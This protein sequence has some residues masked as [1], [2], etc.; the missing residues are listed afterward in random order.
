MNRT[1]SSRGISASDRPII[2]RRLNCNE[3]V[4]VLATEY[5]VPVKTI[6]RIKLEKDETDSD[7]VQNRNPKQRKRKIQTNL[8]LHD[9]GEILKRLEAGQTVKFLMEKYNV[10]RK[11]IQRIIKRKDILLE[12]VKSFKT[13]N[14]S[15]TV[16][17]ISNPQDSTLDKALFTWFLQRRST[18]EPVSGTMLQEQSL[19]F[20]EK[21]ERSS[22]NFK[23][24]NGWLDKFKKRHGIQQLSTQGDTLSADN[25][26]IEEFAKSLAYFIQQNGYEF[27][28]IYNADESGLYWKSFPNKNPRFLEERNTAR[29]TNSNNRITAMFCANASGTHKIPLLIIGESGQPESLK[30]VRNLPVKY[31]GQ[32]N[33][34]MDTSVFMEWYLELFIPEV[35]KKQMASGTIKKV[36]LILDNA[37]SHC[38]V[39]QL[40]SLDE[41]FEVMY[42]PPNVTALIQ[43]MAQGVIEKVKRIYKKTCIQEFLLNQNHVS[44]FEAVRCQTLKDCCYRIANAWNLLTEQNLRNAWNPLLGKDHPLETIN[45]EKHLETIQALS[46]I[47]RFPGLENYTY[48]DVQA[49]LQ[50]DSGET[51]WELLSPEQIVERLQRRLIHG[52][53]ASDETDDDVHFIDY[54]DL[55]DSKSSIASH[56]VPTMQAALEGLKTFRNWFETTWDCEAS[57]LLNL[58]NLRDRALELL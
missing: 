55:E 31:I 37:P 28:E 2:I 52:D 9:R 26:A 36:L 25:L 12:G 27:S 53:G 6:Q 14:T 16:K 56:V 19:Q 18:G 11:T 34:W 7:E 38:S 58:Q 50:E 42:V 48:D 35:K 22:S 15:L 23:A 20:S 30:N 8:S 40:N 21:L 1:R 5:N 44:I 49:W 51:G 46:V 3:S 29:S 45:I 4:S 39:E 32:K 13:T 24:S 10:S 54:N 47:Q 33:S 43:P 17:K 57:D 41:N